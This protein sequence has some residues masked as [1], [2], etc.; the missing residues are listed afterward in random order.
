M[1]II[2]IIIIMQTL[3]PNSILKRVRVT[4]KPQKRTW[5][6]GVELCHTVTGRGKG[7]LMQRFSPP[8]LGLEAMLRTLLLK[9]LLLQNPKC[10]NRMV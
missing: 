8:G 1:L 10:E 5:C 7:V 2:M 9:E 4:L 6:L 3:D